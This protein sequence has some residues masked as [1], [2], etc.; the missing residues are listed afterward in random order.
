MQSEAFAPTSN[1]F[2]HSKAQLFEL[3]F[4]E[5]ETD[6]GESASKLQQNVN[7]RVHPRELIYRQLPNMENHHF[8]TPFCFRHISLPDI[9]LQ[10]VDVLI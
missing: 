6:R 4:H 9:D 2:L 5:E 7:K 8:A 10:H 3:H 1:S